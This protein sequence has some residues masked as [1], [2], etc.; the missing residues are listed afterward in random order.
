MSVSFHFHLN[1]IGRVYDYLRSFVAFAFGHAFF[2][3]G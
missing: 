2:F 3:R 1:L